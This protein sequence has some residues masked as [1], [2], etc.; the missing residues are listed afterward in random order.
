M[1]EVDC[2]TFLMAAAELAAGV[3]DEP[4][5]SRM[6]AHAETCPACR[7]DLD[8][9]A[10][11]VDR[12]V[13]L[14][15]A[16]DPPPGFEAA[17]LRRWAGPPADARTGLAAAAG[18][19]G[20]A[21]AAG[22]GLTEGSRAARPGA[23]GSPP[24]VD[25]TVGPVLWRPRRRSGAPA[26]PRWAALAVAAVLALGVGVALGRTLAGEDGWPD[27]PR[28]DAP[29]D[30]AAGH[31]AVPL[32]TP[33]GKVVGSMFLDE[34]H[35]PTL[36][37]V[38]TRAEP[39]ERYRCLL[40]DA[41]GHERELGAWTGGGWQGGSWSVPLPPDAGVDDAAGSVAG[42]VARVVGV[43]LRDEAG[44]LVASGSFA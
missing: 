25:A 30:L 33:D 16:A 24:G 22:A 10:D 44:T 41:A 34:T 12:L 3:V 26:R 13:I 6:L 42:G 40:V 23:D 19:A 20:S 11:A 32:T 38:L 21:A 17:V 43:A 15:P 14:A 5:R 4:E 36:V 1:A 8:G 2:A 35:P 31:G 9:L 7:A 27:R 39:G 28:P 29:A 18:G 37:M